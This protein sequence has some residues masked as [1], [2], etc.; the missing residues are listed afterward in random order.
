MN[1]DFKKNV[2][3]MKKEIE[4]FTTLID[5]NIGVEIG[6]HFSAY[7]DT[8]DIVIGLYPTLYR[9]NVVDL[10]HEDYYISANFNYQDYGIYYETFAILHEIGHLRTPPTEQ[11]YKEYV[12]NKRKIERNKKINDYE[13]LIA[14]FHL[15][16]ELNADK[17]AMEYI[18]KFPNLVKS[19]NDKI[20]NYKNNILKHLDN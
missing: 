10:A 17:W 1:E 4:D 16:L 3:L 11:E 8:N 14:Y 7:V 15:D 5:E 19:F 18:K 20:H 2:L 12:K 6:E 9:D 13:K